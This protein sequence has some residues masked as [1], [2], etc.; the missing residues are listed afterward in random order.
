MLQKLLACLQYHLII[1]RV[2]NNIAI[3]LYE[4]HEL[5]IYRNV[6]FSI[7]PFHTVIKIETFINVLILFL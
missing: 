2:D 6:L 4:D 5:K 1:L 3:I 7:K